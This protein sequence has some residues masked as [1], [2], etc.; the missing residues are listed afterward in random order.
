VKIAFVNQPLDGVLP[1]N[2]NSI[3]IWTYEVARRLSRSC[4]VIVYT[5]QHH[6][7][8]R[9]E[10]VDG[11][12]CR[13]MLL[14]PDQWMQKLLRRLPIF[15]G[16]KRPLF[17]SPSYYLGYI[18]QVAIDLRKQKC[19]VV[20][21]FNFS[22]FVPVIRALNPRIKIVLRMSCEWASQLD[23]VMIERRLQ[24]V[25]LII[26]CSE[27][28]TGKI[29][30]KIP[31]LASR[32]RTVLNARDI[33]HFLPKN[34]ANEARHDNTKR[35]LF[36]G[37]V[38]PEKG[39]HVLIEAFQKVLERYPRA[40]FDI[41]GSKSQLPREY[42]IALT[43]NDKVAALARFYNGKSRYNYFSYLE[44]RLRSLDI[45]SHVTFYDQVPHLELLKYYRAADVFVFPSVWDEPS[46]NP[47]IEAMA[48]G[49]PVV[50]TR[51]GGTAEYVN[52]GK[53]GLLVEPEDE[54]ALADSILK[55]LDNEDLRRSMGMAG[56]K[57]AVK[58][59]SFERQVA[60]LLP[61]YEEIC[62]SNV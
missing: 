4:D 5:G 1:P 3:G 31:K 57:R 9:V 29:R 60:N 61:L 11:I 54:S 36:V 30:D 15:R 16:A 32:C 59:L 56:R 47:P 2:Q 7:G 41:I 25:D 50:S 28:I 49:V 37:R 62:K 19:D 46:G 48:A 45:A 6:S 51:T 22:Q 8:K 23:H 53:T 44:K 17:A 55:L 35:L 40:E 14:R 20:Q 34:N 58:Q 12:H 52:D 21:L 43:D 33:D 38:S 27:Y 18:L 26:G 24:Q 39:V 13:R 10:C 42:L